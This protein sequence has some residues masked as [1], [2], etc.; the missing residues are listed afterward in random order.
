ME[1]EP[2]IR[3]VVIAVWLFSCAPAQA[4]PPF[5]DPGAYCRRVTQYGATSDRSFGTCYR[6]EQDAFNQIKLYW[7]R[8]AVR[9]RAFC[10]GVA[11]SVGGSYQILETCL[12]QQGAVVEDQDNQQLKR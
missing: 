7:D 10:G 1:S 3:L 4:T 6:Q 9:V 2:T 11:E 8:L 5:Y 12:Q